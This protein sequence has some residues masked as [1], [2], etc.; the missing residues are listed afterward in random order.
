ML[1]SN[2][3]N[4]SNRRDHILNE[5]EETYR[6]DID[7]LMLKQVDQKQKKKNPAFEGF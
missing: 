2:R 1:D 7:D 5:N 3:E 6:Y 4:I